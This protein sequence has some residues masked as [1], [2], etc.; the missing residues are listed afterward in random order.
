VWRL[1]CILLLLPQCFVHEVI[2][3]SFA[4]LHVNLSLCLKPYHVTKGIEGASGSERDIVSGVHRLRELI[5]Q[6][7]IWF[8]KGISY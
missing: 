3:F 7:F 2:F 6:S 1:C 5:S 8:M 4:S